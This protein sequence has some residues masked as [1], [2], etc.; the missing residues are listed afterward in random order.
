MPNM[1]Y[2]QLNLKINNDLPT[3]PQCNFR[4]D[5]SNAIKPSLGLY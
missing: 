2:K 4:F 5:G 1:Y 3:F